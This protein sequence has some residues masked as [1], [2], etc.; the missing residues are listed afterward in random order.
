MK[1]VKVIGRKQKRCR[2]C[3]TRENLTIDHKK[4]LS[5]GGL[6]VKSNLQYLCRRCNV[7]KDNMTE[8]H[9]MWLMREIRSILEDREKNKQVIA[10]SP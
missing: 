8:H 2:Y 3:L 1:P 9:F 5:Q 7:A 4:P 10:P 6:T